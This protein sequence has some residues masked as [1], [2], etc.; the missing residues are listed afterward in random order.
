MCLSLPPFS[1]PAVLLSFQHLRDLQALGQKPRVLS[2]LEANT[3]PVSCLQY[4]MP[5]VFKA[6]MGNMITHTKKDLYSICPIVVFPPDLHLTQADFC[7][8]MFGTWCSAVYFRAPF[9]LMLV[10][11]QLCTF[12]VWSSSKVI[13]CCRSC[14]PHTCTWVPEGV[15]DLIAC[16]GRFPIQDWLKTFTFGNIACF[17]L[18]F[19]NE[20]KSVLEVPENSRQC[21]IHCLYAKAMSQQYHVWGDGNTAN[22]LALTTGAVDPC[23]CFVGWPVHAHL[24]GFFAVNW[25]GDVPAQS[26]SSRDCS[27][28]GCTSRRLGAVQSCPDTA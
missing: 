20:N 15:W 13:S 4:H 24:V 5:E 28:W 12:W 8:F 27:R 25:R 3:L 16:F 18:I 17:N 1:F 22:I 11:S 9:H 23:V 19:Q 2:L 21:S 6:I 10:H 7:V 14:S 26:D